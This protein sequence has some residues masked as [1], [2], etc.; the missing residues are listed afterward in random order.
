M[1]QVTTVIKELNA[2]FP[3][4]YILVGGDF[5]LTPDESMDRWPS[6][7]SQEHNNQTIEDF[8]NHNKLIDIR[9]TLN[10][11]KRQFSWFKPNGKAKSTIDYWLASNS[12]HF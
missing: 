5:N 10:R 4:D 2:N 12:L 8:I 3:T 7:L 6:T 1:H 11:D 9:R